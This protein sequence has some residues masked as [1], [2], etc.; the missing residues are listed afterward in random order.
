MQKFK[1]IA[2]IIY[3]NIIAFIGF[4]QQAGNILGKWRGAFPLNNGQEIPFEFELSTNKKKDTI[5]YFINGIEKYIGG[6]VKINK[7]TLYVS[8]DQF[9]NEM[10]LG[11]NKD[12]SLTGFWRKQNRD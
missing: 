12:Q 8:I 10:A 7:D 5:L 11:I 3:F 1:A 9:D 6:K 2:L 4:S